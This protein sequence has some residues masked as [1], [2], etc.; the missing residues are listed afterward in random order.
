LEEKPGGDKHSIVGWA[1][2]KKKEIRA[3]LGKFFMVLLALS[4]GM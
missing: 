1:S 2:Q 4:Y 3:G